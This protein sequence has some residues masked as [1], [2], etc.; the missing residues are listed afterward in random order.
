MTLDIT[1]RLVRSDYRV[2][3]WEVTRSL[4]HFKI[5]ILAAE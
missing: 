1:L 4:L 2:V 3:D 5:V